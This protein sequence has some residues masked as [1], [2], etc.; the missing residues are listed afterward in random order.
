LKDST[1]HTYRLNRPMVMVGDKSGLKITGEQG[2]N[3]GLAKSEWRRGTLEEID[4]VLSL[5]LKVDPEKSSD[6]MN[7]L[8]I[9]SQKKEVISTKTPSNV[10]NPELTRSVIRVK[11]G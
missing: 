5:W 7:A 11:G 10:E 8:V 9:E 6:Y 4:E 2:N 1:G 3:L